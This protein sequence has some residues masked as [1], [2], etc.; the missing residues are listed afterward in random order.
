VLV[1]TTG[2]R[3]IVIHATPDQLPDVYPGMSLAEAKGRYLGLPHFPVAPADDLRALEAVGRWLMKFSP[4]VS[5]APPSSLFL[6]AT[7]IERL[8]GSIQNFRNRVS[9]AIHAL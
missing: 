8:F 7:G 5:L 3:Q 4:N 6:D 9:Q 1:Q 2:N